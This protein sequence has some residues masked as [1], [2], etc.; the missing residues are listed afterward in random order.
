MTAELPGLVRKARLSW[1]K[2]SRA[3]GEGSECRDSV[4]V[5]VSDRNLE[6]VSCGV[7]VMVMMAVTVILVGECYGGGDGGGKGN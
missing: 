2:A 1:R 4:S 7:S 5:T 6:A 3:A